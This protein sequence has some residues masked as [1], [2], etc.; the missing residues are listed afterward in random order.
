VPFSTSRF[1]PSGSVM[2]III[3]LFFGDA[4]I[5]GKRGNCKGDDR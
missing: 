5:G 2:V 1:E 4:K 3:A